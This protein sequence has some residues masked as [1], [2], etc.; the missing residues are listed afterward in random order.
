MDSAL[1]IFLMRKKVAFYRMI[2]FQ[3]PALV[4]LRNGYMVIQKV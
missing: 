3:D 4:Y 2:A 1:F